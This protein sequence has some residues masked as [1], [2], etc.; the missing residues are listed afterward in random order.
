MIQ[1]RN[2]DK[3]PYQVVLIKEGSSEVKQLSSFIRVNFEGKA[4][5]TVHER[6]GDRL[7]LYIGIGIFESYDAILIKEIGAKA[8]KVMKELG[9]ELF[10]INIKSLVEQFGDKAVRAIV[11]GMVLGNYVVPKYGKEKEI[12]SSQVYLAGIKE[13]SQFNVQKVV[14]ETENLAKGVAFARDLVNRPGNLL[15]PIHFVEEIS[16]CFKETKIEVE[17]LDAKEIEK[18]GMKALLTVGGSSQNQ[19]YFVVLR[20]LQDKNNDKV[21]GLVGKGITCDTGGYCLKAANSMLGIKGD[22]AGAAAVVGA[23]YGLALNEK[24]TNVIACIPICENRISSGSFLPGDVISSLADKTIEI[25]NTDAEGRLVLADAVTYAIQKEKVAAV[26]DIATLTGSIVGV[27]GFSIAGVLSNSD[28][29][30]NRLDKVAS[31]AGER[32]L[33]IPYYKEHEKMIKSQIADIKN[34]GESY[35]G[36]IAAGLFIR[37]FVEDKPWIHLDIAGTAWVDSPVFEYQAKGAT[38]AGVTS[39]YHLCQKEEE[40]IG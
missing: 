37:E 11:E 29:L 39:I 10:V 12:K 6:I 18:V 34:M 2:D 5:Q 40:C 30:W 15:R 32:Y 28:M 19:P 17:I 13:E 23:I 26:L 33:R 3:I 31:I 35:C 14:D 21:M 38:G 20:Y 25:I 16:N 9:S 1:V 7:N 8:S 4:L 22:M 36:S 27:L 24:K